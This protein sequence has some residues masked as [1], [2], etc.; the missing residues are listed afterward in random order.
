MTR[1]LWALLDESISY[2]LWCFFFLN[3]NSVKTLDEVVQHICLFAGLNG[4]MV[5]VGIPRTCPTTGSKTLEKRRESDGSYLFS[6]RCVR[7]FALLQQK[8]CWDPCP[9]PERRPHAA[10]AGADCSSPAPRPTTV[11]S[12]KRFIVTRK[13]DQKPNI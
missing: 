10:K 13:S 3:S 7:P 9:G 2:Y 4:E 5:T 11:I 6:V 8:A 12:S 1:L